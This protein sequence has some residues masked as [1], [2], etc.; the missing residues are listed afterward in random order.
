MNKIEG[1]IRRNIGEDVDFKTKPEESGDGVSNQE[2]EIP[3][4]PVSPVDLVFG[5]A[6][7]VATGAVVKVI[8]EI[9]KVK[10]V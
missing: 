4:T 7:G 6:Q 9:I 2:V 1:W 10:D 5:I 3:D 8:K